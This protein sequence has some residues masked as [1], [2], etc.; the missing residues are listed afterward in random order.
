MF[1]RADAQKVKRLLDEPVGHFGILAQ[2]AGQR[3]LA[4]TERT[5]LLA[6]EQTSRQTRLAPSG[7]GFWLN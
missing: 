6:D 4:R 1:T 7:I 2:A 3:L 5:G